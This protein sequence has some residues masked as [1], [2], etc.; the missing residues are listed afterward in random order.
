MTTEAAGASP[1]DRGVRPHAEML[2]RRLQ[3]AAYNHG[4]ED[5]HPSNATTRQAKADTY[6]RQTL[7]DLLIAIAALANAE[8]TDLGE[9]AAR[10]QMQRAHL[11]VLADENERLKIKTTPLSVRTASN[12]WGAVDHD[13][14]N[15][16]GGC[17]LEGWLRARLM[18]GST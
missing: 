1:V 10:D 3:A 9:A 16:G 18:S 6:S 4:L 17:S 14:N 12:G 11:A 2:A 13:G 5:G 7:A 8:R 15:V